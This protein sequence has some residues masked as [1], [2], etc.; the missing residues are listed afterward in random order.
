[1]LHRPRVRVDATRRRATLDHLRLLRGSLRVG[2]LFIHTPP[3]IA[4]TFY[5][6]R[7]PRFSSIHD[8][9]RV[10][11]SSVEREVEE[12][13]GLSDAVLYN[14]QGRNMYRRAVLQLMH[15]VGV[16]P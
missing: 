10:R 14:W 15:A 7:S 9:L 4:S 8:F 6:A 5:K 11:D 2:I 13:I 1:K 12:L 3:D 16:R